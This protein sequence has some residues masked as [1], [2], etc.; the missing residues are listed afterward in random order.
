MTAISAIIDKKNKKTY[1]ASDQMGSDGFTGQN[2]ITKKIFKNKHLTIAMC[3]SYRLGQVLQH[4]LDPRPFQIGESVDEYVFDYLDSHIRKTFKERKCLSVEDEVEFL[5]CAEFIIA[6]KDRIF[7]LQD[8]LAMLEP[9]R[10]FITSGSGKY[11]QEA[12]I[13][14]QLEMN[15]KKDYKE[16]LK[17]AIRYTSK[18]VLSVGGE[19]QVIEHNH[20]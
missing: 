9:E 20:K 18:I 7:V 17:D 4:N 11:H 13:H 2:F 10:I 16:I 3:G 12:S 5:E 6:I 14:T 19:P 1:L 15:S 8:D